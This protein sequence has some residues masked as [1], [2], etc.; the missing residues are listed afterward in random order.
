MI[1]FKKIFGELIERELLDGEKLFKLHS[2]MKKL[3]IEKDETKRKELAKQIEEL[4]KDVKDF[5][6]EMVKNMFTKFPLKESRANQTPLNKLL[7]NKAAYEDM[8]DNGRLTPKEKKEIDIKL[9]KIDKQIKE[10]KKNLNERELQDKGIFAGKIGKSNK[11]DGLSFCITGPLE[12]AL[13]TEY[14][15]IIENNGG[16]YIPSVKD[17]LD[18]LVTND[19]FSGSRKNLDARKYGTEIINEGGLL[20]LLRKKGVK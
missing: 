10:L 12:K 8:I 6:P 16:E 1:K 17:G 18:Y 15:E 3:E 14:V 2:T 19:A 9:E 20:T 11:L 4:E 7:S 13:R 5:K